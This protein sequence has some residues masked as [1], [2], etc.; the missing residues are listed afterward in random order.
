MAIGTD[1]EIQ[2]DKDIRYTGAAHG[3]TGAG[4]YT[5]LEFHRWLQDLADDAASS[6]DDLLDISKETPSD[7]SFDTIIN[8]VNGYNIDQTASEHLYGGS[9]IQSDGDE[10]FDGIA[11]IANAGCFTNI[12]QNGAILT[13]DFWN[14][15]PFGASDLGLNP[16]L[17]AGLSH[18]FILK[19]RT[20]GADID[21]RK[22]I[23]Q[24]REWG[25]TYSEFRLAAG[26]GRGVNSVP[27]T[28]ADDLNN[29]TSSGTIAG[30]TGITNT[31]GYRALDVNN[32]A[33]NEFYYSE[34][35]RDI[36][37]INTFYERMKYL[38]RRGSGST[39]YGLNGELFRGIT[40]ELTVDTP[41]GTF[42][43]VEA[44]SWSGGTGQML[45]INSTT[46]ATKMWIQLLTGV[47]PT[48]NQVITGGT[49][50]ATVALNVTV[51]S[52][53]LSFPFIGASTGSTIVGAYG[54]GLEPLDLS[55]SDKVFDLTNTLR[56]APNYVT[57][58][59]GGIVSGDTV[60]VG[61][62]T[63]SDLD[64]GQ[65]SLNGA[66]TGGT[67]TSVVVNETI[68]ADTPA[69]GTIRILRAN[70][71]YSKHAYSAWATSTFTITSHDF[72]TNNA[73]NGANTFITYIDK[74]TA[75]TSESFTAI[76]TS[77]RDLFVRVRNGGGSPI[78]TFEST[79][80][81]TSAGGSSTAV[82]TSDS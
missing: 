33:S 77:D 8:L 26:T 36:Y 18:Q 38:S 45:A 72:S 70:G 19:V 6:G 75:T 27:L 82:R 7:K 42:S 66:L 64:V 1:F 73:A 55:A 49:S 81:L 67:V 46:A 60:L 53:V 16:N 24:T 39:L 2:S 37:S 62:A 52:R 4:Y 48:D 31:E 51:T 69:T 14:E 50:A 63:G 23:C 28:Y 44:V 74:T 47:V 58:T 56:Q 3:V 68:P 71:A 57:F 34:W 65:L 41:T 30:Y 54:V 15:T 9:I 21:G 61:P 10:I 22:L 40:H 43:A 5:V 79:A 25:K 12:V 17:T 20:G 11:I 13:N 76:Y 59:V 32:D 78:K 80:A 35:N 29:V